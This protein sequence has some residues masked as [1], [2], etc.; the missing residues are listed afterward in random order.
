[1]TSNQTSP[2]NSSAGPLLLGV[3][4]WISNSS[5]QSLVTRPCGDGIPPRQH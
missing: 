3:L 2:V 5:P 1:M 4:G